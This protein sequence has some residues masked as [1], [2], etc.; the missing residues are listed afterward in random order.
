MFKNPEEIPYLVW[1]VEV[2]FSAVS[3]VPFAARYP[4]SL[5]ARKTAGLEA[6]T[7]RG[8]RILS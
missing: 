2:P 4:S 7:A 6:L 8:R 3:F 5:I 1:P